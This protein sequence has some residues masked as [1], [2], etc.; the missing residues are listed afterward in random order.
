MSRKNR[1]DRGDICPALW[2]GNKYA[3]LDEA[4]DERAKIPSSNRL[5]FHASYNNAIAAMAEYCGCDDCIKIGH[6]CLDNLVNI[7]SDLKNMQD[8]NDGDS[9]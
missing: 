7:Y 4:L 8:E 1:I 2:L 9:N 3:N 6:D 5:L